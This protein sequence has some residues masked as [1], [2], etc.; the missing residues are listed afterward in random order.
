[1]LPHTPSSMCLGGGQLM[2]ARQAL[3]TEQRGW[4]GSSE[5][6]ADLV[7]AFGGTRAVTNEKLWGGL[8]AR[9]PGAIVLGCSTGGEIHGFDVLDESLSLTAL[10]FTRTELRSA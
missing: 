7:L 3:W 10:S 5:G 2:R 4:S 6:P 8:S 1:M 9:H